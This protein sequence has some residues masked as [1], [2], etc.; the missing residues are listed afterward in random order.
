MKITVAMALMPS[1][2]S[3]QPVLC[4]TCTHTQ[5]YVRVQIEM[6]LIYV[7]LW[8]KSFGTHILMRNIED[9]TGSGSTH[10]MQCHWECHF[11]K[12]IGRMLYMLIYVS[13]STEHADS[14]YETLSSSFWYWIIIF[15]QNN[16]LKHPLNTMQMHASPI[17]SFFFFAFRIMNIIHMAE[18]SK[19]LPK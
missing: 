12:L 2:F 3:H 13:V 14:I 10:S 7:L 19:I 16:L 18:H 15:Y 17:V 5:R 6:L 9:L 11:S 8:L 4:A 1:A